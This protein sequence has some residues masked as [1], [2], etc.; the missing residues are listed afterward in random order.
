MGVPD[1]TTFTLQSVVEVVNPTTDDL[2]DCFADAVASKFD[3]TYEGNKDRLLNFRNYDASTGGWV[4]TDISLSQTVT[5]PTSFYNNNTA[6]SQVYVDTSGLKLFIVDNDNKRLIQYGIKSANDLT[7]TL[8]FVNNGTALSYFFNEFTFKSDGTKAYILD[9]NDKINEHTLTTA[10]DITT[11]S[12]TINSSVTFPSSNSQKFSFNRTGTK[13]YAIY[14]SGSVGAGN[15]AT[16]ATYALSTAWD[17]STAASP[18]TSVVT[19][20]TGKTVN[21]GVYMYES[22]GTYDHWITFTSLAGTG[23]VDADFRDGIT[24]SDINSITTSNP[25]LVSGSNPSCINN[26]FIYDVQRTGSSTP[27]T[28]I[29]RKYLTNV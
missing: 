9:L 15:V 12:A 10:F 2:E 5:L 27:Y 3:P 6:D 17:L 29:I 8:S 25:Q 26:D 1:T 14:R 13:L 28:F 7:S 22:T 19:S 18:T 21:G 4:I 24:I 16:N 11:L 23:A 20:S